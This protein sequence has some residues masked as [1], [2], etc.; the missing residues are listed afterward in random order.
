MAHAL[1]WPSRRSGRSDGHSD[2]LV[3][4][5]AFEA[6]S[7][8]ANCSVKDHLAVGIDAAVLTA[9]TATVSVE[10]ASQVKRTVRILDALGTESGHRRRSGEWWNYFGARR[11]RISLVP[12]QAAADGT[13]V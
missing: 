4:W 13:P 11:G 6:G 1:G 10:H 2:T 7:T 9:R 8:R 12:R 5:V 3:A